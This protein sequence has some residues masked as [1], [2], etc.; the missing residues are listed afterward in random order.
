MKISRK[1]FVI[2]FLLSAFIFQFISNSMLG[3]EVGLFPNNGDFFPGTESAIAWKRTLA[4]ILYPVRFVLIGPLS[5]LFKNPDPD[6][7]PPVFVIAF[8]LY[9]TVLALVLNYLVNK[10]ITRKKNDY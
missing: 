2:S 8:A 3:S 6:Q 7:P 9:W 1:T 5:L 4:T 10:I